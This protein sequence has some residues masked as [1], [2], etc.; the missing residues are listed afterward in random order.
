MQ[1]LSES[2]AEQLIFLNES[3]ACERIDDRRYD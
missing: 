2:I 3:V 1:R